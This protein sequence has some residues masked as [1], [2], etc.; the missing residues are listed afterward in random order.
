MILPLLLAL[1]VIAFAVYMYKYPPK[2]VCK[3]SK[4]SICMNYIDEPM[5][6]LEIGLVH[7]MVKGYRSKQL[8]CINSH[9]KMDDGSNMDD[10]HSIWF[11]LE[12]V[13]AFVYHTEMNAVKNKV[14]KEDLGLRIYYSRYPEEKKWKGYSDLSAVDVNYKEHHTLVMIP[15]IRREK[16]NIDFN[17]LDLQ[18]YTTSMKNIEMYQDINST[19]KTAVFG[20]KTSKRGGGTGAQNHGSLIPPADGGGE[21]V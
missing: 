13:K 10:A 11:D 4:N 12:T 9:L 20:R 7:E 5:S 16:L 8:A 1:V 2:K 15:T 19:L 14:A 3:C 21:G 17:P 18:T 6:V